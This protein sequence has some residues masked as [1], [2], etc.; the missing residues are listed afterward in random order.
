MTDFTPPPPR[1]LPFKSNPGKP[2]RPSNGQ[3]GRIFEAMFCVGCVHD[4]A[5]HYGKDYENGCRILALALALHVEDEGYPKEWVI[6]DD[7]YPTCTEFDPDGC[8]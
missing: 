2:Y 8:S 6:H 7:G 5:A 4:H 3:E 1:I